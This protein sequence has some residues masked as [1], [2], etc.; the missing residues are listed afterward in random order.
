M[1][2]L[3]ATCQKLSSELSNAT[4]A[5]ASRELEAQQAAQERQVLAK[6][7]AANTADLQEKLQTV[8][9]QAGATADK[10]ARLQQQHDLIQIDYT[11]AQQ[12]ADY[13]RDKLSQ[14]E[15]KMSKLQAECEEKQRLI[16]QE[17]RSFQ[18]QK[19]EWTEL[20]NKQ[21][22]AIERKEQE[23]ISLRSDLQASKVSLVLL[24]L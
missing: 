15:R 3:R 8:Q 7:Y 12:D 14:Q 1:V 24:K 17:T 11:K 23:L 16:V 19:Q 2:S 22:L 20:N 9:Q 5:L 10:L 21:H 6:E 4:D 18:E 13:L